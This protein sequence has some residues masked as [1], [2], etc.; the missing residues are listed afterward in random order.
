MR[1]GK[2]SARRRPAA[3]EFEW[4]NVW[5]VETFSDGVTAPF[6]AEGRRSVARKTL[7]TEMPSKDPTG[8]GNPDSRTLTLLLFWLV[9]GAFVALVAALG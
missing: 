4:V 5:S 7:G 3:G 6:R 1:R 9:V 8:P 2:R